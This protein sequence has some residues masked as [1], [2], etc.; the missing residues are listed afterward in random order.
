M[1]FHVYKKNILGKITL[2][3]AVTSGMRAEARRE[4]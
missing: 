1:F 2:S 3:K 4:V